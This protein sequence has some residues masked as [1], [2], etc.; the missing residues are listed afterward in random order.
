MS[1]NAIIQLPDTSAASVPKVSYLTEESG[2]LSWLLTKDHKRI[3]ILYLISLSFFF[4]LGGT[5]AGLIR[6]QLL[7]PQGE[8]MNSDTL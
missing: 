3:G 4:V 5:L 6:L 1:M 2:L 7:T 8:L